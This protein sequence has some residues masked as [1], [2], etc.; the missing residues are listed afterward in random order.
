MSPSHLEG[1]L[2][3]IHANPD[4]DNPR[5]ILADYLTEHDDPRGELIRVQC[6]KGSLDPDDLR[7]LELGLEEDRLIRKHGKAWRDGSPRGLKIDF[8]R[9]MTVVSGTGSTL[10]KS[11]AAEW[12]NRNRLWITTLI[13]TSDWTDR[14]FARA[15][16]L[17]WDHLTELNVHNGDIT[18]KSVE[19]ISP[20]T[21]LRSLSLYY[22]HLVTD[23]AVPHLAPLTKLRELRTYSGFTLSPEVV[24]VLAS[25]PDLRNLEVCWFQYEAMKI[26]PEL[27]HLESL[28][29]GGV[30]TQPIRVNCFDKT[31]A[32]KKLTVNNVGFIPELV[33]R[34]RKLSQFRSLKMTYTDVS[35]ETDQAMRSWSELEELSIDPRFRA[36]PNPPDYLKTLGN[37]KTLRFSTFSMPSAPITESWTQAIAELEHVRVLDLRGQAVAKDGLTPLVDHPTLEVLHLAHARLSDEV[38]QDIAK[39]RSLR[40]IDLTGTDVAKDQA[41]WLKKEM[42]DCLVRT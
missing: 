33:T 15:I 38:V 1:F 17:G 34:L 16:D 5:L 30:A 12:W 39:L 37:L 32:L 40:Y 8:E 19:L 41:K 3:D 24:P 9:G 11:D 27:P 6:E 13:L 21:Q 22:T 4:D 23:A 25:F 14:K 7:A 28:R 26:M 29:F 35:E 36:Q 10:T 31:P 2:Q 18:D 42:S 20:L